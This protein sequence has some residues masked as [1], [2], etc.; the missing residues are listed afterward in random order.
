MVLTPFFHNGRDASTTSSLKQGKSLLR[1]LAECVSAV[2]EEVNEGQAFLSRRQNW[3]QPAVNLPV[4]VLEYI[5]E[6]VCDRGGYSMDPS[7]YGAE[8]RGNRSS[9]CSVCTR[10]RGVALSATSIWTT[11]F[12][13]QSALDLRHPSVSIEEL[14]GAEIALA[15]ARVV[16]LYLNSIRSDSISSVVRALRETSSRYDAIHFTGVLHDLE[17]LPLL[18]N[19][20]GAS[21]LHDLYIGWT[22]NSFS[23]FGGG[24]KRLNLKTLPALRNLWIEAAETGE[25]QMHRGPHPVTYTY[26]AGDQ[27]IRL[28]LGGNIEINAC[29]HLIH[30]CP[31]LELL[32][33]RSKKHQTPGGFVIHPKYSTKRL[34]A[35]QYL[36]LEG[37]APLRL[38]EGL[39]AAPNL[40]CLRLR[41]SSEMDR[42]YIATNQSNIAQF[43]KLKVL[44]TSGF[45]PHIFPL[46]LSAHPG[47]EVLTLDGGVDEGMVA[48]LDPACMN[49][50]LLPNLTSLWLYGLPLQTLP[51][52][53]LLARRLSKP[54]SHTFTVKIPSEHKVDFLEEL[55]EKFE[56][57][58]E[59]AYG[60][61]ADIWD[62]WDE[63]W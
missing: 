3:A 21:V 56:G 4:E 50:A 51:L 60:R 25:A 43:P 20:P 32:D 11:V 26:P 63:L 6:A 27:I 44:E 57:H 7:V 12:I 23:P 17:I 49:G 5:F 41:S 22:D 59:L 35:L 38:I 18:F 2:T 48:L 47:I 45:F 37:T 30:S 40:V 16:T 54:T 13:S 29:L 28:R 42:N 61:C 55:M 36:R 53:D 1:A 9:I 31:R 52:H 24:E 58:V 8:M 10:W 15:Q 39:Q 33:W 46:F 62:C 34:D 19:P 14:V